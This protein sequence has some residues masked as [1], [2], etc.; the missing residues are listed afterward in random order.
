MGF[1]LNVRDGSFAIVAVLVST[2]ASAEEPARTAGPVATVFELRAD[3]PVARRLFDLP[4]D[5]FCNSPRISSDGRRMVCDGWNSKLK[6]SH[7][8]AK[9]LVSSLD[10]GET[11]IVCTGAMPSLSPDG[12]HFACSR[13]GADIGV[14][15]MAIDGLTAQKI[16]REGW[17]IQWSPDGA[18]LAYT[19]GDNLIV[20]TIATGEERRLFPNTGSPYT[21]LYWNMSWSSDSRKIALLGSQP[22]GQYA[23][24]TVDAQG[25]ELGFQQLT[26][27]TLVP[28]LSWHAEG[29]PIVFPELVDKTKYRMLELDPTG[30]TGPKPIAGIPEGSRATSAC[31]APDGSRLIVICNFN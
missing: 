14:W 24:A 27:G 8:L 29:R 5:Y 3:Q 30:Q 9:V 18:S 2:V 11:K 21:Q 25:A 28:S 12:K 20:R 23:L 22:N 13:Y 1:R 7:T 10:G 4:Q 17:G 15:V 6:E 26:T 19:R 31:W 16:D